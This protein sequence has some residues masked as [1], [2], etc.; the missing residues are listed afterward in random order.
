MQFIGVARIG[1]LFIADAL[2]RGLVENSGAA[3]VDS[4]RAPLLERCVVE[5]LERSGVDDVVRE[6]RRRHRVACDAFD[7]AAMDSLEYARQT[8]EVHRFFETV[9][10]GL[11]DQRMIG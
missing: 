1:T 4:L 8:V 9:A 6:R 11:I 5:K 2:H 3:G 7:L 10:H